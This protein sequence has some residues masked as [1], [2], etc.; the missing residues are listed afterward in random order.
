VLEK[1][2]HIMLT[3]DGAL[4]FALQNGFRQQNLLSEK[5]RHK[6]EQWKSQ[7]QVSSDS[8]PS[9]LTHDTICLLLRDSNGNLYG[10]CSTSGLAWKMPG[11][12]GDTPLIGS[13]LYVD[14]EIGAAAATGVGELA[15]NECASFQVV[16]LMTQYDPEEACQLVL[17][18]VLRKTHLPV[19]RQLALIAIRKDGKLGYS[20]LQNGF[21]AAVSIN[22]NA[23]L[24][25]V[26]PV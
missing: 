9:Y 17:Q 8:K 16:E 11:R 10:G 14:N 26:V 3:G 6:Y 18:R 15:I 13:G 7:T 25:D 23:E 22:G 1:T 5:A 2:P 20:C 21:Q 4:E 19:P 24:I 12:V